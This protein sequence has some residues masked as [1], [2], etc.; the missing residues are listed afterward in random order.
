MA[1]THLTRRADI[2]RI[3]SNRPAGDRIIAKLDEHDH[4][5]DVLEAGGSTI[6]SEIHHV[7]GASTGDVAN[8]AAF[9]VNND[10]VVHTA[11]KRIL[12]KD[13]TT[14]EQNGIYVVGAVTG[15]TAPLTR[16]TDWDAAAEIKVNTIVAVAAGT[17]NATTYWQI[18]GDFPMVVGTAHQ[19]F[20]QVL[21]KTQLATYLALT[22]QAGLIGSDAAGYSAATVKLQLAEV[23]AI[24]DASVGAIKRTVTV[25]ETSLTG[26]SQAVNIGA[27]LPTN[28]CVFMHEIVVNTQGV[29]A[30]NDLTITVGGTTANAIV[31]STDLDALAPGKYQGT[32]GVHPRGSFSGEQ[33]VATFAASDLASLSA[34]NWTINVWYFVLA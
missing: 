4:A 19:H 11:G 10:G 15:G 34:G 8:L 14:V 12:L 7:D 29:L 3:K 2:D 9:T 13:Q 25:A 24:A 6:L 18:A 26:T 16:A 5:L 17:A 21:N 1:R 31:A 27:I 30:G 20:V 32:L 22:T 33:L 23:K 28:A